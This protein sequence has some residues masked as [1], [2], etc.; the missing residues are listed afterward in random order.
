MRHEVDRRQAKGQFILAGSSTP[1]GPDQ[2]AGR[3]ARRHSGVGRFGVLEMR[4][5]SWQELG[6]STGEISLRA[7]LQRQGFAPTQSEL[8]A[9]EIAER[10]ALGGW[11]G[12]LGLSPEAAGLN[13]SNYVD[14][15]AHEDAAR[16]WG[17][18]RDS[19]RLRRTLESLA[20]N[21]S[22]ECA[23]A[24]LGKDAG[25]ADG[26]LSPQTIAEYLDVFRGLMIQEDLPSWN[27]HIRSTARLRKTPKRHLADTSLCC[28]LLGLDGPRLL[29]DLEY[30]GLLFEAAVIHDLRVYAGALGGR[31]YFYRD[32]NSQEA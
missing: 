14:L 7:V 30:M 26:P 25:G 32:S 6:W 21:V 16:A 2:A 20:R 3:Q 22:T 15:L 24:T 29:A 9:E 31:V 18:R 12:N 8:G 28:A 19:S 17:A 1:D 4:T 11:P 13:N 27:T 5:L 10:L 23:A